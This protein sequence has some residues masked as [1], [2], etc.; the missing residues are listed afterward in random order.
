MAELLYSYFFPFQ[1]S[2][3][4][5]RVTN[6]PLIQ[7][8][9]FLIK[10]LLVFY[11]IVHLTDWPRSSAIK[12]AFFPLIPYIVYILFYFLPFF[13]NILHLLPQYKRDKTAK[14]LASF[15]FAPHKK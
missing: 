7:Q 5:N 15:S 9:N 3:F 4:A 6:A 12:Y 2:I 8:Q 10:F 13:Y 14:N 11:V 1:K